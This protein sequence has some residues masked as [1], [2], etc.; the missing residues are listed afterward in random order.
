MLDP[1]ELADLTQA[2]VEKVLGKITANGP[3]WIPGTI[4]AFDPGSG[5]AQ[6]KVDGD[7]ADQFTPVQSIVGANL[8]PGERVIVLFVPPH[9]AFI[10]GRVAGT[11]ESAVI[12]SG[13]SATTV[14]SLRTLNGDTASIT[15]AREA[16]A[17]LINDLKAAHVI[18]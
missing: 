3:Q 17:T 13:W 15:E 12:P 7:P 16:L 11:G 18:G 10:A 1:G 9:G 14:T 2:I 8:V 6:V 4:Q 5:L